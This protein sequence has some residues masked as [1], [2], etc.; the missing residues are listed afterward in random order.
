VTS[1]SVSL[2]FA[3]AA[4][5][6]FFPEDGR[7]RGNFTFANVPEQRENHVNHLAKKSTLISTRGNECNTV[8]I[9]ASNH[10]NIIITS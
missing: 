8:M 3:Q 1:D 4:R 7:E 6:P 5:F 9:R 10:N 2:S